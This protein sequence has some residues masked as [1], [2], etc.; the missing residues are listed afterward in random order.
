MAGVLL[1]PNGGET[2]R[3]ASACRISSRDLFTAGAKVLSRKNVVPTTA[4]VVLDALDREGGGAVNSATGALAVSTTRVAD[5]VELT[6]P[7]I[8][9]LVLVTTAVGYA[10]GLAGEFDGSAFAALLVGTALISG[11]GSALNQYWERHT[12]ALML[13]TRHRPLPGGRIQPVDALAFSLILSAAGLGLL[14]TI[15]G[16][17]YV[18]GITALGTYILAYT[19]LKRVSSLCTIVGA[20]PGAIPPLMGWAAAHGSLRAGAWGLFAVLFLW[21][22]PHFLAIGWMY[23]K[24]YERGGFPMLMVI[25]RDGRATARQMVLS[26]AALVPVTV[27][28][29]TLAGS[30][31]VYI[32]G[33]MVLGALFL[34]ATLRFA[35]HRSLPTARSAL[36]ISVLYLPALLGLMAFD[37]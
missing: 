8:T 30:G 1:N 2:R 25:D 23:R 22:L 3:D 10:L 27:L 6:K 20:V 17:V 13:R 35:R 34:G 29:G 26:C 33:A 37:R 18:L 9:F 12:D 31:R 4:H 32:W 28:A 5:F 24:D 7:R 36:L 15:N 11:G 16:V 19:P 21:Q 14:A